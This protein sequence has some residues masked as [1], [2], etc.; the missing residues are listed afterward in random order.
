MKTD[1]CGPF[2]L[3]SFV[4]KKR[5]ARDDGEG[6]YAPVGQ[7]RI[8]R[9]CNAKYENFQNKTTEAQLADDIVQL[10]DPCAPEFNSKKAA[11]EG[12]QS[13]MGMWPGYLASA[14]SKEKA[15][16][17]QQAASK[18]TVTEKQG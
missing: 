12:L 2:V 10:D 8:I 18:E 6:D 15:Q 17:E 14:A 7:S 9:C 13:G 3:V 16:E 1:R 4:N 5:L 11:A